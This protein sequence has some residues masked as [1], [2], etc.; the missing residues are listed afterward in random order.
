M[1][2]V[3]VL[4][5]LGGW[6]AVNLFVDEIAALAVVANA[7]FGEGVAGFG[8][9]GS[10]V[11]HVDP[12]FLGAVGELALLPVRTEPLFSIVFAERGLGLVSGA[13]RK[14]P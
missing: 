9:V 11:F 4:P 12:Q 13:G 10:I 8:L 5:L 2:G 7:L 1:V 6:G 14:G 3:Y